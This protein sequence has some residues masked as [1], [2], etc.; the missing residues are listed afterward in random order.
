MTVGSLQVLLDADAPFAPAEVPAGDLAGAPDRD[1]WRRLRADRAAVIS[2]RVIVVLVLI[3]ILA[4]LI[5]DLLGV[6]GPDFRDASALNRFG[7]PA[8]LSAGHPLGV[9]GMGRDVLARVLYGGRVALGVGML[10]TVIA[11]LV[12]TAVGLLAGLYAGATEKVVMGVVDAFLAFPVVVLG[13][14]VGAACRPHGCLGGAVSSGIGTLVLVVALCGFPYIARLVR[15]RTRSLREESF[16]YAARSL[17]APTRRILSREIMP[18]L[19]PDLLVAASM[20]IP[21][22]I[23][24]AAA[25]SFLGV[26]ATQPTADWGQM[27]AAAGND[28]LAGGPD[29]W[30]LVFPGLALLI[31]V[32]AFNL[33]ADGVRD[34]VRPRDR[35]ID[36]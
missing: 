28:V 34:A 7:L 32:L 2:A 20:L 10:G 15:G 1:V 22:S 19:A 21:A 18:N 11:T 36:S 31:T 4:P 23:V 35:R 27:I 17:G 25:V 30:A 12:G 6:T 16:V 3:A 5:V 29:W 8:G 33:F 14:G 26:G 9:D 13:L 24:L